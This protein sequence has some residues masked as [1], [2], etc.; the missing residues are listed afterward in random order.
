[1]YNGGQILNTLADMGYDIRTACIFFAD[2]TI[3]L[4]D[5]KIQI[6]AGLLLYLLEQLDF[7]CCEKFR[8]LCFLLLCLALF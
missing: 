6:H 1:V 3:N 7:N 4:R 5:L 2:E 8:C